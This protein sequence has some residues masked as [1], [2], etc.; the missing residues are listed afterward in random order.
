M[1]PVI[2][3]CA[4]CGKEARLGYDA[5]YLNDNVTT[6]CDVCAEVRRDAD[7]NAFLP[8]DTFYDAMP[9]NG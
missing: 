8:G 3:K 6:Y 9:T 1:E 7:G 5:V 4:K 2:V